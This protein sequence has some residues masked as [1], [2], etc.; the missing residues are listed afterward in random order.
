M[1][2][3]PFRRG[4]WEGA[5]EGRRVLSDSNLRAVY[6]KQGKKSAVEAGGE[7][8]M[9]DPGELFSQL[10]GGKAFED[11]IGEISL[12]KDVSKAFEMSA[13]EEEKEKIAKVRLSLDPRVLA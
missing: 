8:A 3:L 4:W 1:R 13:S 6:N 7:G 10:F 2:E 12:G 11:W 5:D 9:P